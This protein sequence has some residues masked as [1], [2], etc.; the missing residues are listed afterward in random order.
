MVDRAVDDQAPPAPG[1]EVTTRAHLDPV[2]STLVAVVIAVLVV[3]AASSLT[4]ASADALLTAL[5]ST[6][7][8][9]LF[10]WQQDRLASVIPALAW[11][12]RAEWWNFAFQMTVSASALFGLAAAFVRYHLRHTDRSPDDRIVWPV[13]T[14]VTGGLTI[15]L[16]QDGSV[17]RYAFEQV[18]AVSLMALVLGA[19]LVGRAGRFGVAAGVVL[20]FAAVAMNPSSVVYAPVAW[21][22]QPPGA[23]WRSRRPSIT[24]ASLLVAFVIVTALSRTVDY[25]GRVW[26]MQFSIA[27][28][29]EHVDTIAGRIWHETLG[30]PAVV[31]VAVAAVLISL[32]WSRLS[33]R[34]RAAYVTAPVFAIAWTIV[35]SGNRWVAENGFQPRYFF[36]VQATGILIVAG[37]ATAAFARVSRRITERR[38]GLAAAAPARSWPVV[39]AAIVVL[40]G[41]T[42]WRVERVRPDVVTSQLDAVRTA[43][44]FDVPIIAGDYWFVWPAVLEA[45]SRGD[46]VD[47]LTYRSA[48][49]RDDLEAVMRSYVARDEPLPIM[50]LGAELST[51][52]D[53]FDSVSDL[54][55]TV[56]AWLSEDPVVVTVV[57]DHGGT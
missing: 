38:P 47:G 6:R 21:L 14:L 52:L 17:Y 28:M 41:L 34:A 30:W 48:P 22:A 27:A 42:V 13:A 15:W 51:C 44:A 12:I 46:D 49:I 53:R 1:I 5:M 24:V 11:P 54:T 45:R 19:A 4:Y 16:L 56:A 25:P 37:G 50:C 18:Y 57:A 39:I 20:L 55:W 29:F 7:D 43:E 9:T 33:L 10:Y 23:S 32:D 31:I 40:A 3:V 8:L 26:Y 35:F 36:P 2:A